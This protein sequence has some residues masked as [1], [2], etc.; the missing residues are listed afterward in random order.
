[1]GRCFEDL[2]ACHDS[3]TRRLRSWSTEPDALPATLA[4]DLSKP[5]PIFRGMGPVSFRP[6]LWPSEH[7]GFRGTIAHETVRPHPQADWLVARGN[8]ELGAI[9]PPLQLTG[10]AITTAGVL[11]EGLAAL[12]VPN[13]RDAR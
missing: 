2:G 5:R 7:T 8:P 6:A 10:L 12:G 11:S 3:G 1:M 9:S 13:T 4:G